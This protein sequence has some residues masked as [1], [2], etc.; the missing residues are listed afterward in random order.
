ML[1]ALLEGKTRKI[2]RSRIR[3]N[4]WWMQVVRMGMVVLDRSKYEVHPD[5]HPL[6]LLLHLHCEADRFIITITLKTL[7]ST[8]AFLKKMKVQ[9]LTLSFKFF[10]YLSRRAR[11]N[12]NKPNDITLKSQTS[13]VLCSILFFNSVD[14]PKLPVGF[15][16]LC[17][18]EKEKGNSR[19]WYGN[20]SYL[21]L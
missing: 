6:P 5:S 15:V 20:S 1:V 8:N 19:N 21:Q 2:T 7:S 13:F 16:W 4:G 17:E 9:T 12:K 3:C 10:V 18:C 14:Q 11:E